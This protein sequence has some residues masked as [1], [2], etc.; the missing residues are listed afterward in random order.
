MDKILLLPIA[1]PLIAGV[2]ALLIPKRFNVLTGIVSVLATAINLFVIISL[3]KTNLNFS[4]PW[5]GMGLEFSLKLYNFSSFIILATAGFGF[6][7]VLYSLVFMKEKKFLN[8][9]YA[10]FL[11][12]L[13]F[14]IGA[15]LSDNLV[16][17]FFFWEASLLTLFGMIAIGNKNAFKTATKAFIIVGI[18]DLCMMFGI[19][20]TGHLA[21]TLAISKISL[22]LN[23]LGSIA[24][25]FLMIGAI[26]KAGSMPF[27]SWIP[28]AAVDA[29][30]P[31][32]A[33]LPAALEKLLG[34][35]FLTRISMDMFQ[36]TCG[37]W[38]SMT[39]MII[40]A[41]TIIFAVM[42][43]LV[44]SDYKRLLSYHAISQV[45]YMILGIGTALPVGIIGG[46]FHMINNAL[47]KSC[48]FLTGGSVEKQT[49]T[50]NL[51]KLGGLAR[52]MPITFI[53]FIITAASIS[54]VPPFNGFFSKELVYDAALERN[55]IFY[56]AAVLG[57]FFTAASFLK[58]GH[59]AFL[60]KVSDENK[61]V[62]EVSFLMLAPMIVIASL[63][64][65]F[66]IFNF[67]PIK[68]LIQPILGDARLNGHSFAG[69]P[70]NINLVI[71][72]LIVLA[73]A[74]INHLLGVK[75]KGS[76]LKAVDHIHY[77]PVLAGI[78]RKAEKRFFDP[79]DIGLKIAFG[80]SNIGYWVDRRIDWLYEIFT[81]R[82]VSFFTNRIKSMHSGNYSVY[83]GWSLIGLV[84][85]VIF[86]IYSVQKTG[87]TLYS[88]LIILPF[89]SVILLNL[90]FRAV[91]KRI[92]FGLCLLV[93][94]IQ[95]CS[96]VFPSF[97]SLISGLDALGYLLKLNFAADGLSRV[98]FFSIGIV[99]FVSLFVQRYAAVDKE[100]IF[101][102]VNVLLLML[103]GM[104]G[105][106]M[107][108]DI[109]SLYA[110]LEIVAIGSF[111]LIGFN[112][113]ADAFEAAF[114]YIV[115]SVIATVM[116]LSAIALILVVSGDTSFTSI[117]FALKNSPDKLLINLG[118]GIFL[119]A[120]FIKA[121]LMPFH[122]WLPDAYSASPGS[123]SILLAGIGTK[124]V[125]VYTLIR[126]VNSVFGFDNSIKHIFLLI[127]IISV[128]CG[129]L[130]A[131][132]QRDFR[133]MLAYSSISQVGYIILGLGCG[134]TLGLV[135][136]IFHLFNHSIFKS[137][138]FVNSVTIEAK[139]GTKDI[140]QMS[141]L[142]K[143]MPLTG[144]TS[145]LASLSCAGIPPLA[146]FWSKLIIIIALWTAGFYSYAVIS[147]LAS[148][149]TL[150]Y[151]LYF[152]REFYFG[153]L[154]EEHSGVKEGGFGLVFPA[155]VLALITIGAGIFFAYVINTFM[156]PA[157]NSLGV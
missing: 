102:F 115:L 43:A 94:S 110:F 44:Q 45:G 74:L 92:A 100:R 15:V 152:L 111:I 81:V 66:G 144:I 142:A 46:L 14:A 42:M 62:K 32:M 71:I 95:I 37:S 16:I 12:T 139:A 153:K 91:M 154:K 35:Y 109:F 96:I 75:S 84:L 148:V 157:S 105:I 64:V 33:L 54:G 98:L 24:F 146:G 39:L 68:I 112:K 8:Q 3:F 23:T 72:T 76:G 123:V 131:L 101:N 138:L 60:G 58:L 69:F 120:C 149:L 53:C 30:L 125:G 117:S 17:M 67:I 49:G 119:C 51:E 104:N 65:I 57:S 126:V 128:V 141:G 145:V 47:Y 5:V 50:T 48:L 6:L 93:L 88:S 26:S 25:I 4:L 89:L 38:V 127:G 11:L 108:R 80:F 2:I 10:Y 106:V 107:V 31:F 79:Y 36:L 52:K 40:G 27:H 7:I 20:L 55:V 83:L 22:P 13:A 103:I 21:G 28:D 99:L 113:D 34:I 116:M 63:C 122:G 155:L 82:T 41:I 129:A 121:G 150:A 97:Y 78:Y 130:A 59:A 118:I 135:G 56:I 147:I 73:A 61:N 29:P 114:K 9:F 70:S 137:L 86:L 77:A 140:E 134:T 156:L 85:V 136:A 143:K 151:F 124:V 133:R 87:D 1:I 132:G 18:T 19:I 90:P